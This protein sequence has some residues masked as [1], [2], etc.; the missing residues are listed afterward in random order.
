LRHIDVEFVRRR[1]LAVSVAGAAGVAEI[2]E[3][4]EVS[5]GEG[6]AHFH[7]RKYRAKALAVAA[8]IADRHQTIC[9]VQDLSAVHA[10]RLCR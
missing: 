6:A 5:V 10:G 1:E 7:R 9:F 3:V 8:G 2:G 4:V